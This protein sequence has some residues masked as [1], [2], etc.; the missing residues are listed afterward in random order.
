MLGKL[1]SYIYKNG[2]RILPNSIHKNKL[3]MD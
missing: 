3:Q 1:D 2:I